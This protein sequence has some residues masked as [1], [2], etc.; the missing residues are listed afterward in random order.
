MSF[1]ASR[2]LQSEVLVTGDEEQKNFLQVALPVA[3]AAGPLFD[4]H[5]R[6]RT[7]IHLTHTFVSLNVLLYVDVVEMGCGTYGQETQLRIMMAY[8]DN[9]LSHYEGSM[10]YAI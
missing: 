9:S 8:L 6:P 5:F 1:A 10:H 4:L 3:G 7:M 2:H